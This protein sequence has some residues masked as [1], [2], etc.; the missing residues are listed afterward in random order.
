MTQRGGMGEG[1]RKVQ[2]CSCRGHLQVIKAK[3]RCTC[4]SATSLALVTVS[5]SLRTLHSFRHASS[6]GFLLSLLP[7]PLRLPGLSSPFSWVISAPPWLP[8]AGL[9][10]IC[11]SQTPLLT[12]RTF[13]Y[14][15]HTSSCLSP[16][17]HTSYVFDIN[18][19]TTLG[20]F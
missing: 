14:L 7:H 5:P 16:G 13:G 1:G 8:S 4:L 11:S 18:A 2:R 20:A 12:F 3:G 19:F 17:H 9:H 6:P 15:L 10:Y